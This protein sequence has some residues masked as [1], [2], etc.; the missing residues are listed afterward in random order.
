M[1][2]KL[3]DLVL[4]ALLAGCHGASRAV[5]GGPGAQWPEADRLFLQDP[6]W[7]GADAAYS[8]PL[9]DGRIL[10]L[11]GD[12]FV[13]KTAA[14]IRRESTMVRN[15]IGVQVGA[16]PTTATMTFHW[17]GTAD[18]PTS[19]F[20]QD[21]DGDSD[22]WYWP[23]HGVRIG[24][25]L[26]LFLQRVRATPGQGLGFTSD[27]WRA[28]IIADASGAP[29]TWDV[30]LVAPTTAPAGLNAGGAVVLTEGRVVSLAV[31]EPGDHA[32][33]LLRWQPSDLVAGRIEL[34][35][36]WT[37]DDWNA[38]LVLAGTVAPIL[39]DAGP[40]SSLHFETSR[41]KWLHV[42]SDG[43]GATTIVTSTAER[44][45]GP[46]SAPEVR[47]RPPE[48]DRSGVLVYAAKGHP[49]QDAGGALAVTYA[50][51]TLDFA[52]LLDDTSLYFPR[53]VKLPR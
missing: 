31:R 16:D 13:A 43:F 49:E 15:S 22:H 5:E 28:A 35:E 19:F 34:A 10:W 14:H 50:T 53:F 18:A 37:D 44:I 48:S 1:K 8:V 17:R 27:G 6:R 40:E 38:Q 45:T 12:T 32:G 26:V 23:G 33:Y 47:F 2:V 24:P 41:Q 20:P 21:G 4:C 7:L 52:T 9:D 29:E 25:A 30:Q 42:R 36:W 3:L 51:N 46:W 39:A 11:F